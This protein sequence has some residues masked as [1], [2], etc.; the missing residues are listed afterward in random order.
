MSAGLAIVAIL[1]GLISIVV[2]RPEGLLATLVT[3][4]FGGSLIT[5]VAVLAADWF[6]GA[7]QAE[8]ASDDQAVASPSKTPAK[9]A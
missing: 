9:S 7:G 2:V 6:R 1:G 5:L 8:A 3:V 4:S